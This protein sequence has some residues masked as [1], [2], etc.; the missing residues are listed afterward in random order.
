M[1]QFDL[2]LFPKFVG[3]ASEMLEVHFHIFVNNQMRMLYKY[4]IV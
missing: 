2:F 1:I 3:S 4:C